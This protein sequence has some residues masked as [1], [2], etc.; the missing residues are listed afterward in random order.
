MKYEGYLEDITEL[1]NLLDKYINLKHSQKLT[2]RDLSILS[3][4]S[5]FITNLVEKEAKVA[6]M[7]SDIQGLD[8][9]EDQMNNLQGY[10][11]RELNIDLKNSS[12][13]RSLK[14]D[15]VE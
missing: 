1:F 2:E 4:N 9:L 6:Q 12:Y 10:L 11:Q 8:P 5:E 14:K 15:S 7:K 3:P 13:T